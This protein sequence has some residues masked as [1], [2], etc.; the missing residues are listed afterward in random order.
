MPTPCLTSD[1]QH[2]WFSGDT[3][4]SLHR[5]T[6]CCQCGWGCIIL[7]LRFNDSWNL[8]VGHPVLLIARTEVLGHDSPAWLHQFVELKLF[9]LKTLQV[10][11]DRVGDCADYPDWFVIF[12]QLTQ[13]RILLTII[14][15]MHILP[16]VGTC[17]IVLTISDV[18]QHLLQWCFW[19]GGCQYR[20]FSI[21]HILLLVLTYC[22]RVISSL[23]RQSCLS[24]HIIL[25]RFLV[26]FLAWT[27]CVSW[28]PRLKLHFGSQAAHCLKGSDPVYFHAAVAFSHLLTLLCAVLVDLPYLAAGSGERFLFRALTTDFCIDFVEVQDVRCCKIWTTWRQAASGMSRLVQLIDVNKPDLCFDRHYIGNSNGNCTSLP[29]VQRLFQLRLR[30]F[31]ETTISWRLFC[32]EMWCE[33]LTNTRLRWSFTSIFP[34][35]KRHNIRLTWCQL[36]DGWNVVQ[37]AAIC[38]RI[39]RV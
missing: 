27:L 37:A 14:L 11:L 28:L 4:K 35:D 32:Q 39:H 38:S 33:C 3:I 25:Y 9:L 26:V 15:I 29:D 18:V 24:V 21:S 23:S 30:G 12:P 5:L 36:Q 16:I 7:H 22:L 1:L 17:N 34:C 19:F 31:L 6:K 2:L 8:Q 10:M 13:L 20:L